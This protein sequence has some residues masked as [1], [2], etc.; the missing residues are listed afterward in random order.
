MNY[1]DR[2][3]KKTFYESIKNDELVKSQKRGFSVIPA[4]AEILFQ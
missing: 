4:K 2:L 3:I 1:F